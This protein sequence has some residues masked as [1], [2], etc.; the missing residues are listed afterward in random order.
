MNWY[1]RRYPSLEDLESAAWDLGAVVV[2]GAIP[3]AFCCMHPEGPIIGLPEGVGPLETAWLL[4]H[5]LGHLA[6]HC[7]YISEWTFSRQEHGAEAWAACALIPELAVQRYKNASVDA[8][9]GA[10]SKHYE[11]LPLVNCRAREV[12]G[13]IARIR[14]SM[15][16]DRQNNNEEAV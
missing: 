4:A 11:D 7:G 14:L 8:F 15:V 10:L 2:Y 6:K 1:G 5:E 3:T 9:I 16:E 13:I 12:A